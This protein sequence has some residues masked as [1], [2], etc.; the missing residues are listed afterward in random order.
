MEQESKIQASEKVVE[1]CSKE[2]IFG[3]HKEKGYKGGIASL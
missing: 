1:L 3:V 2:Y